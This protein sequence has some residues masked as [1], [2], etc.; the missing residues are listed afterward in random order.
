MKKYIVIF[1]AF[2]LVLPASAQQQ[3]PSN[4][5][6]KKVREVIS[7]TPEMKSIKSQV[8]GTI[9]PE[10]ADVDFWTDV[11][12]KGAEQGYL[13]GSFVLLDPNNGYKEEVLSDTVLMVSAK[14]LSKSWVM[15][16][17]F[18]PSDESL[19][20]TH[21][22]GTMKIVKLHT[23]QQD[24]VAS[25]DQDLEATPD[26]LVDNVQ[27]SETISDT[28]AVDQKAD[29]SS[30]PELVRK[31]NLGR[32]DVL[33][34]Y[35]PSTGMYEVAYDGRR[36]R[37]PY[38]S[39][40]TWKTRNGLYDGF[41][42]I[43]MT[44]TAF[45]PSYSYGYP[46]G[47]GYGYGGGWS[48]GGCYGGGFNAGLSF[49]FGWSRGG[50]MNPA[51]CQP[52]RWASGGSAV[53]NGYSLV[54]IDWVRAGMGWV[55][56]YGGYGNYGYYD[57]GLCYKALPANSGDQVSDGEEFV[58]LDKGLMDQFI[59]P[60]V[61]ADAPSNRT[62]ESGNAKLSSKVASLRARQADAARQVSTRQSNPS[63]EGRQTSVSVGKAPVERE[64]APAREG[65]NVRTDNVL[66][67]RNRGLS[68]SNGGGTRGPVMADRGSSRV[69]TPQTKPYQQVPVRTAPQQR[70]GKQP[71]MAQ[72]QRQRGN[73]QQRG[74]SRVNTPQT[75]PYQ[76]VPVRTAP[77]QRGG[78]QPVMAQPQRQRGNVQRG[79]V[80]RPPVMRGAKAPAPVKG[81]GARRR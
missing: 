1:F 53:W 63:T 40:M 44:S 13:P 11:I 60:Q 22:V 66:P 33:S 52:N 36:S 27:D 9:V 18:V 48:V 24:A 23:L 49:N 64:V 28:L 45:Y 15:K 59:Q 74:S 19:V 39:D 77:Q 37:W 54:P 65:S 2:M 30:T 62:S 20:V 10:V 32:R 75:K 26:V 38:R 4:E 16:D 8:K 6:V 61:I 79:S 42:L 3:P 56:D 78:K 35:N 31:D 25:N 29:T 55:P 71:V 67:S 43:P 50:Y 80:G 14:D 47:G 12:F 46:Y 17:G 58:S 76:Q 68:A 34:F 5:W 21:E 51:Y 57:D 73:V 72:P 7:A 70:G 69:N 81:A 41:G